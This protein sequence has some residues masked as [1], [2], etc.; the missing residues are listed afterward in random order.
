[1]RKGSKW[2][3]REKEGENDKKGTGRLKGRR[4][5]DGRN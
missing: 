1:M 3:G 4:Q 2:E 5:E